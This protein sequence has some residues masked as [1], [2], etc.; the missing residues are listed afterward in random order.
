MTSNYWVSTQCNHWILNHTQLAIARAEDLQYADS[1]E[2]LLAIRIW[3]INC[4][5][6]LTKRLSLRQRITATSIIFFHRFYSCAPGNSFSSTD[7]ALVATACVYVASKV[8]ETP[9]HVRAVVQEASKLWAEL[10]HWKFPN[11]VSSLAEME[12]YLLEDLHFHMIVYHPYRSLVAIHTACGKGATKLDASASASATWSGLFSQA[13]ASGSSS[14]AKPAGAL[15]IGAGDL[16]GS[17]NYMDPELAYGQAGSGLG[18]RRADGSRGV[19]NG[20][21]EQIKQLDKQTQLSVMQEMIDERH[22]MF[23]YGGDDNM[24]LP[25]LEELDDQVL[26]MAWFVLNDTYRTDVLLLYPPHLVAVSA[27]FLAIVLHDPSRERM[28]RSKRWMDDR[29]ER[30]RNNMLRP[31]PT[32]T[33]S[34]NGTAKS[35]SEGTTPMVKS[36]SAGTQAS[37]NTPPVLGSSPPKP[38]LHGNGS[39]ASTAQSPINATSPTFFGQQVAS[40]PN[41]LRGLASLPPRPSHLPPKPGTSVHHVPSTTS[42][43]ALAHKSPQIGASPGQMA[44]PAG[45]SSG[46][47]ADTPP[48]RTGGELLPAITQAAEQNA[49]N[50]PVPP[51]DALTFLAALNVDLNSVAEIVQEML[52]LYDLWHRISTARSAANSAVDTPPAT[53]ANSTGTSPTSSLVDAVLG[54][55]AEGRTPKNG[56]GN[57]ASENGGT[58]NI[59]DGQEMFR[60]LTKLRERRREDLLRS[61]VGV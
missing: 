57:E 51:P 52:A 46:G 55:G 49:Y 29:R 61:G 45:L 2:E 12:F 16:G 47:N 34:A 21:I 6:L 8:E 24:P 50:P 43:Q 35:G 53:A 39:A 56:S 19:E 28:V 59:G 5:C 32:L 3:L 33:K 41:A 13:Q 15:P 60:R 42:G 7:P 31:K 22:R 4:I 10:G 9:V 48:G 36:E 17:S 1:E 23:W 14:N 25:R 11:D 37:T 38:M 58:I 54:S 20:D 30:Y 27:I 40:K 44:S 18:G 26:Q